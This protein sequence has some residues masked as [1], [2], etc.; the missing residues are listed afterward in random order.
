[1]RRTAAII[2]VALS[3]LLSSCITMGKVETEEI[4]APS[5]RE[6]NGVAVLSVDMFSS[7]SSWSVEPETLSS[8]LSPSFTVYSGY[9]PNYEELE[10]NYL[11]AIA[12]VATGAVNE[13]LPLLS[14][15]VGTLSETPREFI[16][17][18][19]SLSRALKEMVGESVRMEVEKILSSPNARVDEA[20]SAANRSFEEIRI[21]YSNLSAVGKGVTLPLSSGIDAIGASQ[22]VTDEFFS[23]LGKAERTLK[24]TP[25][26]S[27][28]PY[29]VFWE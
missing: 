16:D 18:E 22:A 1:M 25:A 5:E 9:V 23:L 27:G 2:I 20:F 12:E 7:V 26:P 10:K 11:S 13:L 21:A 24:N 6:K 14:K 28:S 17:G 29:S 3:L 15:A 19:D 8:S 4:D